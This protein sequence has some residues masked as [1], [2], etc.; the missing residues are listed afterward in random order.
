VIAVVVAASA[1]PAHGTVTPS[2]EAYF[3]ERSYVQGG[4]G[5]LEISATARTLTVQLFRAGGGTGPGLSGLPMSSPVTVA[6]NG[7][8]DRLRFRPTSVTM[9]FW[10]S[11]LYFARVTTNSGAATLAPFVLR[12]RQPDPT[13]VAVVL[14]TNSWQAYNLRDDDGDGIPDSWYADPAIGSVAL[15][16]PFVDGGTPPHYRDYDRGFI[17]WLALTGRQPD[18]FSDDDLESFS[19]GR[20]LARRYDLIVFSG[21]EEYVTPHAYALIRD[22]RNAGGNLIFLS[23]NNFFYRVERRN[24]RIYRLGRYRDLGLPEAALIGAQYVDWNHGVYPNRPYVVSG[25]GA[26]PW[27]FRGTGLRNGSRFG[28]YGI[29][30]DARAPES[31]PGTRVVATIPDIFGAGKSAEMTYYRLGRAKVFD[32]GV[33]NFGGTVDR[34]APRRLM[35]NLWRALSNP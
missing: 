20:A 22:Y 3:A 32:A 12:A 5:V 10:P 33:I 29:E 19:S 23:A 11:G 26:A 14:P 31:P 24:G 8:Y 21:H 7:T 35:A 1:I 18:F 30:I 4:S 25:A 13:R 28:R 15:A 34:G 17:R 27:L 2:I 9:Q 6:W 16:R